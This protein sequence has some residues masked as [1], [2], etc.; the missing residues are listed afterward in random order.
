M[1]ERL[2]PRQYTACALVDAYWESLRRGAALPHRGDID[3]RGIEDALN[4]AFIL[5]SLGAGHARIR[6]AGLHLN[7]TMGMEVRGMPIAALFSPAA[8]EG[9]GRVIRRVLNGPAKISLTL[10]GAD[11]PTTSNARMLLL[12]LCDDQGVVNR[13][14]GTFETKGT[15]GPAPQRFKIVSLTKT[16]LTLPQTAGRNDSSE[17]HAHD[18]P[19]HRADSR[20]PSYLRLVKSA[21]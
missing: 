10:K 11:R 1:T 6:I 15:S 12:P 8:R 18:S 13:I 2:I 5:E 4:H 19:P 14:L 7:E 3:P 21:D 9:F 16:E 20:Y 17:R